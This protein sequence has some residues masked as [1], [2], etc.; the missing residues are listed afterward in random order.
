MIEWNTWVHKATLTILFFFLFLKFSLN[1][2]CRL[3]EPLLF[4]FYII[5]LVSFCMYIEGL[6]IYMVERNIK[7]YTINIYFPMPCFWGFFFLNSFKLFLYLYI[8]VFIITLEICILNNFK[9]FTPITFNFHG[10]L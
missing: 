6:A 1:H 10:K 8:R 2:F 4:I 5:P 3:V 9:E 7:Q